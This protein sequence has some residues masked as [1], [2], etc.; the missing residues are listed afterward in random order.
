[1]LPLLKGKTP[2]LKSQATLE[3]KQPKKPF[4]VEQRLSH[5]GS[6]LCKQGVFTDLHK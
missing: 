5:M 3:K 1:M 6:D 4:I 2:F